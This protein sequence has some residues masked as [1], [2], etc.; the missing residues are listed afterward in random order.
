MVK[1][2]F[3][4]KIPNF[5]PSIHLDS[6]KF[7]RSNSPYKH[8]KLHN[9]INIKLNKHIMDMTTGTSAYTNFIHD[10]NQLKLP[11]LPKFKSPISENTSTKPLAFNNATHFSENF[12]N[13][14][15]VNIID[16]A[17]KYSFN[18]LRMNGIESICSFNVPVIEP[19]TN[20]L[21]EIQYQFFLKL[22]SNAQDSISSETLLEEIDQSIEITQSAPLSP[23]EY[24]SLIGVLLAVLFFFYGQ[25]QDKL[26][27]EEVT[28]NAN[29]LDN[30][31]TIIQKHENR[32][33]QLT[34]LI[35]EFIKT[36][37]STHYNGIFY[38]VIRSVNLRNKPT[39]KK[40]KILSILRPGKE[41]KLIQRKGKWIKVEYF[42][43]LSEEIAQG[44]CYKKY[45]KLFHK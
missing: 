2:Y 28:N 37:Q 24:A 14:I 35:E 44:W 20:N 34:S 36:Q 43:Y 8:F 26:V 32:I 5:G 7:L 23:G 40:S 21:M 31:T 45:L 3:K 38:V 25:Y 41:V 18:S 22:H 10:L 9:N 27:H 39:T 15:L 42:D 29:K 12:I 16:N 13:P 11:P 19:I 33:E 30:V 6:F 17:T 1:S 4:F